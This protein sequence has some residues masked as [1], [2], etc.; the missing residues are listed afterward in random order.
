MRSTFIIVF[1]WNGNFVWRLKPTTSPE[2]ERILQL[3]KQH[4]TQFAADG[5]R[6]LMIS[7]KEISEEDYNA[8]NEKYVEASLSL[9]NRQLE[10]EKVS[11]SMEV[12]L[13]LVGVTGIEDRL[14]DG[15]FETH[16]L[17]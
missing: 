17:K 1:F 13:T 7:S 3:S 14:Q 9:R 15:K 10:I 6:T 4:T 11:E 12:H 16:H 8:W 2:E 5:L